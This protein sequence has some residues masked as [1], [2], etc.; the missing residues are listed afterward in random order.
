MISDWRNANPHIVQLWDKIGR[1]AMNA[2][3]D[4]TTVP[5]GRLCF[6]YEHSI[7]F[8]RLP[9]GRRL[10]CVKPDIDTNRFGGDSM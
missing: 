1:A 4:K 5:L 9:G 3:K 6:I 7:L 10:S 8:I 2:I